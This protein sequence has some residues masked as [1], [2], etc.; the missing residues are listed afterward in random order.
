M[1]KFFLISLI[2]LLSLVFVSCTYV[3]NK[4]SLFEDDNQ[5]AD[6]TFEKIID[7]IKAKNSKQLEDLFSENTIISSDNFKAQTT[8]FIKFIEGD[9]V[10]YTPSEDNGVFAE[11]KID[12]GKVKKIIQPCFTLY[13]TKK[14]Y[15]IAIYQ[16][17]RDDSNENNVGIISIYII[18][19]KYYNEP[20]VYR[21]DGKWTPGI[22]IVEKSDIE[23]IEKNQFYKLT[24]EYNEYYCYFYDSERNVVKTEG[25]LIKCP[26]VTFVN[27]NYIKLTV[28]AGT[29]L[30]TQYGYYYDTQQAKF[31]EVFYWILA[32]SNN[33]VAYAMADKVVVQD[34]F[35]KNIY[36]KEISIFEYPLAPAIEPIIKAEFIENHSILIT[37]LTGD[38]FEEITELFEL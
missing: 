36:Y 6:K 30:S 3:Y 26:K 21:G 20:Y 34:I 33:Q 17:I 37:Y 38:I 23:V 4:N 5:I 8:N 27:E 2:I 28:Q 29:G 14:T 11:S 15:H 19:S 22:N 31:S 25:P 10:S 32:E 1:K 35:D 13:T 7:T 9:I 18:D 16:C 24:C 12:Y